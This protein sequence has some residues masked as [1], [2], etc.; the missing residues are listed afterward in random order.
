MC[1]AKLQKVLSLCLKIIRIII[2][3]P[4]F[5]MPDAE[6]AN[7]AQHS[8]E[9]NKQKYAKNIDLMPSEIASTLP[10]VLQYFR[11]STRIPVLQ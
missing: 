8:F 3:N 10:E 5:A 11:Q 6:I 9:S 2:C 1:D 4:V 7:S